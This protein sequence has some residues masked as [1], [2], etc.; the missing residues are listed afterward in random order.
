[1]ISG[2]VGLIAATHDKIKGA[3][4][5]GGQS[6]G[7]ALMSFDK[8][9]FRSYGWEKNANSPVSPDRAPLPQAAAS[10]VRNRGRPK[11]VSS[12]APDADTAAAHFAAVVISPAAAP[13]PPP[14]G[15]GP[16]KIE[17]T[18]GDAVVRVSGQV[19]MALLTAVLRAVRRAS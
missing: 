11:K 14:T 15:A 2:R 9:A 1:M 8:A 5:L 4:S 6:A 18:I 13:P 10:P 12:G 19:D 17:I 16:G 7:V 3:A